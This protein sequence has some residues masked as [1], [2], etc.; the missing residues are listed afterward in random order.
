MQGATCRE[1]IFLAQVR[2]FSLGPRN[3]AGF[4]MRRNHRVNLGK[5]QS[6]AAHSRKNRAGTSTYS[7]RVT[8][9][10][11]SW[12]I[13]PGTSRVLSRAHSIPITS[14]GML[15]ASIENDFQIKFLF[16]TDDFVDEHV[17]GPKTGMAH[18]HHR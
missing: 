7:A 18:L 4:M 16:P 1:T 12:I 13:A 2:Q 10:R 6:I 14:I 17:M 11:I 9:I 8:A 15:A 3:L 5:A